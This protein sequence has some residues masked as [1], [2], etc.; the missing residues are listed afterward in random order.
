MTPRDLSTKVDTIISRFEESFG[1]Q[2]NTT[3]KA[4]FDQM[5]IL[6]NK[7][8]LNTDGTII[9]NQSNRKIL[10]KAD[11][12]YNAAFNQSGYYE[13]L[14]KSPNTIA[15]LTGANSQYFTEV[16]DGFTPNA[17]YIKNLQNQTVAQMESLLANEGLEVQMKKPILDILNQNINSGASLSDVT[18]Q[19]REFI[20]GSDKL[21]PTLARYSKQIANDTLFNY[22]RSMQEAISEQAELKWYV[23]SGGI[24]E[25]SRSFCVSKSGKYYPKEEVEKWA[26]QN[27]EGKR[28]G[29]TSST[30]FIYAGG[31]FCKHQLIAVSEAVV[32][33]TNKDAKKLNKNA[34]EVG[35]ELD[36][37]A[38]KIAKKNGADLTPLNYKSYDSTVRKATDELNGVVLGPD[39]V[40]DAVRTTII[41]DGDSLKKIASEMEKESILV[42]LKQQNYTS[43]GY[44]GYLGNV[45][46]SDGTFGEI[47]INTPEMIYAKEQPSVAKSVIGTDKWNEINKKTGVQGGLG[48]DYY[49][50]ERVLIGNDAETIAKK[51]AIQ[52]K[53]RD[54]YSKFYYSYPD[55]P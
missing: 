25:D 22:S 5:Q 39:G 9:Q 55:W 13:A 27:W 2:V 28:K 3:Q 11:E 38:S 35:D 40:K 15:S 8:D 10:A 12:Y 46:L 30:I 26:K 17:Q 34:K 50:Q 24:I 49:E 14:N 53:S 21:E 20:L 18:A 6:L 45:K 1:K 36:T 54:Y 19:L 31:Y 29:T 37:V 47:Q 52:A 51:E 44:R 32:P 7:L 16:V 42:K 4:L 23:Y 48:H 33:N 43:T 41:T